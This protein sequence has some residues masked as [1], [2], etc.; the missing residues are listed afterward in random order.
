MMET[1]VGESFNGLPTNLSAVGLLQTC[2]DFLGR[3]NYKLTVISHISKFW[4][5]SVA[6]GRCAE[7]YR[8]PNMKRRHIDLLSLCFDIKSALIN[9]KICMYSA[10]R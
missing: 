10:A 9:L 2:I 5:I 4:N 6:F 7:C 8:P 1:L 3:C